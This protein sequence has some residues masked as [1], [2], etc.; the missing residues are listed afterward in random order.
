[1]ASHAEQC[2]FD[3]VALPD[4]VVAPAGDSQPALGDLWPDPFLVAA[5]LAA[6][7]TT[8][9]LML[10][11]SVIPYRP[12]IQQ[13]KAIATLDQLCAGRLVLVAGA[14]WCEDEFNRLGVPF[15]D[16]GDITDD[17]LRAMVTL[18]TDDTPSY[19]GPHAAFA[20]VRFA[21]RCVQEPHVPIWIAG[22]GR[23]PMQRLLE[24][25]TGWAP[26]SGYLPTLTSKIASA[27]NALIAVGRKPEDVEFAFGMTFGEPDEA[28]RL[29]LNHIGGDNAPTKRMP[30]GRT[31]ESVA[32]HE[33][34]GFTELILSTSWENPADL[35]RRIDWFAENVLSALPN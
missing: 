26:M 2:G 27:R 16:R 20:P 8:L 14:G 15:A 19:D 31:I 7:T 18:W 34:A 3:A 24:L 22:S 23:R 32:A 30:A 28:T 6:T 12:V 21:P 17:Y 10:Y 29:A 35:C 9:R 1:V 11:A 5:H 13:A 25:G 33:Q 4:H